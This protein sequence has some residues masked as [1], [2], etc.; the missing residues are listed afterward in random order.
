[1]TWKKTFW[2]GWLIVWISALLSC[3]YGFSPGG[4]HIDPGIQ[5]IYIDNFTNN[6]PEANV[7]NIFRNAFI[8]RF[9]TTARFKLAEN[10]EQADAI[11]KAT[12]VNLSTSHLSYFS[13]NIAREDR[14]TVVMDATF[15]TKSRDILWSNRNFSWY[16]DYLLD[17]NN[18]GTTE[19]NRKAALSKLA[20]DAADRM[21]RAIMSGF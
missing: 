13:T 15:E 12:I 6:T 9:R 3:G 18:T 4:E 7:E 2:L 19:A 10:R 20:T 8:D 16:A 21:Y 17:Q 1:M 5:R 11:L 14:V